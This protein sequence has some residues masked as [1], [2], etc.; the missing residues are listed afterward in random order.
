MMA[1][2]R[3][4][5]AAL[6]VSIA[7]NADVKAVQEM[8]PQ[9]TCLHRGEGDAGSFRCSLIGLD[10][11]KEVDIFFVIDD[12]STVPQARLAAAMDTFVTEL[13]TVEPYAE[14]RIAVTSTDN[15][16]PACGSEIGSGGVFDV[17]SC[18]AREHAFDSPEAFAAACTDH[19]TLE[20]L[21]LLPTTTDYDD[22]PG[23]RPWLEV[24]P[25]G[26]GN[27]PAG[28]SLAEALACALPRGNLGCPLRS[29]LSAVRRAGARTE[30]PNDP[31]YGFKRRHARR[32]IVTVTAGVECSVNPD[33][34]SAFEADGG[35]A[36]W[37]DPEADAPT[38]AACWNAGVQCEG[39]DA[40]TCT[41][42]DR[43][44]DGREAVVLQSAALTSTEIVKRHIWD[45]L[46]SETGSS[47]E[48]FTLA[49]VP[50]GWSRGDSIPYAPAV[51]P[52]MALELGVEPTCVLDDT[53]VPPPVRML[54]IG[55]PRSI[56]EGDYEEHARALATLI[57]DLLPPHCLPGC[58]A[59]VD[60]DAPG[61]QTDCELEMEHVVDD[62]IERKIV[63]RCLEGNVVPEGEIIC[64]VPRTGDQLSPKCA[65]DGWNLEVEV[66][67]AAPLVSGSLIQRCTYSTDPARD[68]PNLPL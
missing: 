4:W 31:A 44:P 13:L 15:G 23:P 53:P 57:D 54:E 63:P 47:L 41:P 30:L 42:V 60:E 18:R 17:T 35:R 62:H 8:P 19:C 3:L 34:A 11:S 37:S 14:L 56:C 59:D 2:T 32:L 29:P 7:C 33:G 61:L 1:P 46:A 49:G 67:R 40:W 10:L 36:L 43:Y 25:F 51:D 22:E 66:I 48:F 5:T 68:C 39:D 50:P 52:D 28:V 38:Q 58:V 27:L 12:A 21:E 26:S 9:E 64:W 45:H 24:G 6:T 20:A 16:N 65:D 55:S